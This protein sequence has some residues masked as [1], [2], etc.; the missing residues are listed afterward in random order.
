ML[1]YHIY[2]IFEVEPYYVSHR[3][4]E[5]VFAVIPRGVQRLPLVL[6]LA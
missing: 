5:S 2:L 6:F 3:F 1:Q 4:G